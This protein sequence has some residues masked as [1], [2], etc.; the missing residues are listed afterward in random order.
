MKFLTMCV[1]AFS[2]GF[3]TFFTTPAE[4]KGH[5]VASIHRVHHRVFNHTRSYVRGVHHHRGHRSHGRSVGGIPAGYTCGIVMR[6]LTGNKYG[7]EYNLA[8]NWLH[9]SRTSAQ[10]GAV[11]VWSRAGRALGGGPG[12]HVAMIKQ[13][14]GHCRAI[15]QDNG[16]TRER[17][18]CTRVQGYV[19]P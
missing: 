8:L 7:P 3:V 18:I 5:H 6:R 14:T 12:G 1:A 4:A 19:S 2:I 10:P 11:V 17:D 9:L 16:G 13:L 15:V